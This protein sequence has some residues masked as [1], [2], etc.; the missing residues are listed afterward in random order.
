MRSPRPTDRTALAL[1]GAW[2]TSRAVSMRVAL[3]MLPWF[4]AH[5][6]W[7]LPL[8]R[9]GLVAVLLA[10]AA[11]R[12]QA[13]MLVAV[14]AGSVAMSMAGGLVMWWAGS[15]FGLRVAETAARTRWAWA[16][17]PARLEQAHGWLERWGILAVF[18][19]RAAA[20]LTG[21]VSLVA[22]AS[23]MTAGAFGA[24]YAA[25]SVAW[26]SAVVWLGVRSGDRWPWLP[27]R[28]ESVASWGARLW[29][30]VLVLLGVVAAG[31]AVRRR[32]RPAPAVVAD[33]ED[34]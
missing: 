14:G 6:P 7:S 12:G 3:V 1:L 32:P 30:A 24:A 17:S 16:W 21:P 19:S 27:R 26:T 18:A 4:V 8:M 28:I 29:L 5:A 25:G 20:L 13:G 9:N 23:R 33:A 22:G 31:M 34:P 2:L 15:R 10:S 11:L